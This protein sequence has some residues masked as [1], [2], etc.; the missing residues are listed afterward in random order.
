VLR[1]LT[2][3]LALGEPPGPG[4]TAAT[5]Y[6]RTRVALPFQLTPDGLPVFLAPDTGAASLVSFERYLACLRLLGHRAE[7][8]LPGVTRGTFFRILLL[9]PSST[10]DIW[11]V[12]SLQCRGTPP[13]RWREVQ[14]S[15]LTQRYR[16]LVV[17]NFTPVPTSPSGQVCW[18][19][20]QKMD[21][22]WCGVGVGQWSWGRCPH[23]AVGPGHWEDALVLEP[24]AVDFPAPPS[25]GGHPAAPVTGKRSRPSSDNADT[26]AAEGDRHH[27]AR[28][29]GWAQ[30]PGRPGWSV[31]EH[32][33][34]MLSSAGVVAMPGRP[35][36]SVPACTAQQL[37]DAIA[38][39][40]ARCNWLR[41][42][43]LGAV[44]SR[45]CL[46]PL[47]SDTGLRARLR[48]QI[49]VTDHLHRQEQLHAM[50]RHR[51]PGAVP[52]PA[53]NDRGP[54][55][56]RLC[57]PLDVGAGFIP[58]PG[59]RAWTWIL[60]GRYQALCPTPMALATTNAGVHNSVRVPAGWAG[61]RTALRF[62]AEVPLDAYRYLWLVSS[63]DSRAWVETRVR[64]VLTVSASALQVGVG[65]WVREITDELLRDLEVCGS[66][67]DAVVVLHPGHAGPSLCASL[68][69]GR[70]GC[71]RTLV[72]GPRRLLLDRELLDLHFQVEQA[73][74]TG[75]HFRQLWNL[76]SGE[77]RSLAAAHTWET[78]GPAAATRYHRVLVPADGPLRAFLLE[79]RRWISRLRSLPRD[80]SAF[81]RTLHTE[82][83]AVRADR[84][85][86]WAYALSRLV[87]L[88]A[89][90][91]VRVASPRS[92]PGRMGD[93]NRHGLLPIARWKQATR[94]G[95]ILS[96]PQSYAEP[97]G[98]EHPS[99]CA[100]CTDGFA[101][102]ACS[103]LPCYVCLD[104]GCADLLQL[105]CRHV[106]CR[107]CAMAWGEQCA[108]DSH[109]DEKTPWGQA[110]RCPVCRQSLT[111]VG[112]LG[113]I[114][115]ARPPPP[116]D[117]TPVGAGRPG[118]WCVAGVGLALLRVLGEP[119]RLDT[120][121]CVIVLDPSY[122]VSSEATAVDLTQKWLRRQGYR[123]THDPC[124]AGC[125]L[126]TVDD[127][128]LQHPELRATARVVWVGPDR[129]GRGGPRLAYTA[130]EEICLVVGSVDAHVDRLARELRTPSQCGDEMLLFYLW[131]Q[132]CFELQPQPDPSTF[133]TRDRWVLA[134][135]SAVDL[136]RQ[137][138]GKVAVAPHWTP[139]GAVGLHRPDGKTLFV[140]RNWCMYKSRTAHC[141]FQFPQLEF[142]IAAE[143]AHRKAQSRLT[144]PPEIGWDTAAPAHFS[145]WLA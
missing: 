120:E 87:A 18:L 139:D 123:A 137:A 44:V 81:P 128:R 100:A 63:A 80:P 7:V 96:L 101:C 105:Q 125:F 89:Q 2:L 57:S 138:G 110:F 73:L 77:R 99:G 10:A 59:G 61:V 142:L 79:L 72:V 122:V 109:D 53:P 42:K 92:V 113:P 24:V 127:P 17:E 107:R 35:D 91:R 129:G 51:L 33:V 75:V 70:W 54:S 78:D 82:L 14:L 19:L 47:P 134:M 39:G 1:R 22:M 121:G 135:F 69:T 20:G 56:G 68:A 143:Q 55:T 115:L 12:P 21:A 112:R 131:L 23:D 102:T 11:T 50:F 88:V 15:F 132:L 114:S 3:S 38:G 116:P 40:G 95:L 111:H 27:W 144:A 97:L 6:A 34:G 60:D 13:L 25:S 43:M 136:V 141:V 36:A 46:D 67:W 106:L 145:D 8:A 48:W 5:A 76:S 65:V 26:T 64:T 118:P 86:S 29:I 124:S 130:A 66:G 108:A 84:A 37:L 4:I 126:A 98:F 16:A 58:L 28:Q 49:W 31:E 93:P 85:H 103:R 32:P 83:C 140:S 104:T 90:Q 52:A 45:V 41:T 119:R 74:G 30:F 133:H 117:V 62:L 94:Y 71:D 9:C